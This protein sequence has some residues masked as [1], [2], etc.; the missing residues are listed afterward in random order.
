MKS[1]EFKNILR[2]DINLAQPGV[3]GIRYRTDSCILLV[4]LQR[5]VLGLCDNP[6]ESVPGSI[7]FQSIPKNDL[8]LLSEG[9][10]MTECGLETPDRSIIE[11]SSVEHFFNSSLNFNILDFPSY[12]SALIETNLRNIYELSTLQKRLEKLKI[13]I[14]STDVE[15]AEIPVINVIG[16]GQGIC[17]Q[18]D[19]A[20]C[21]MILTAR[22]FSIGG[23]FGAKW[24]NRLSAEIRRFIH[25]SSFWGRIWLENSLEG[26]TGLLH[27]DFFR[28]M[29]TDNQSAADNSIKNVLND[30]IING[31]AFLTGVNC[32]LQIVKNENAFFID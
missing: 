8:T 19:A 13:A 26:L 31:P 10:I 32:A 9:W 5:N 17:A 27:Q 15:S 14:L 25:R 3:Y 28:A 11:L 12:M 23:R 2:A 22:F 18:G 30:K 4:S 16:H 29:T 1:S 21:G 6:L 24:F 20:L 7:V